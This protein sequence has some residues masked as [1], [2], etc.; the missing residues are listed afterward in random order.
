MGTDPSIPEF[1][2]VAFRIWEL[3]NSHWDS[4]RFSFSNFPPN[5]ATGLADIIYGSF[6]V[7]DLETQSGVLQWA[8]GHIWTKCIAV[9][10]DCAA[11]ILD[12]VDDHQI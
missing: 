8:F 10:R 4:L 5:P 7:I 9:E 1:K 11:H 12:I 2:S 3:D 6:N